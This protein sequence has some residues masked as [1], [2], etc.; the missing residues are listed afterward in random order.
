MQRYAQRAL[1]GVLRVT[2]GV[3]RPTAAASL[4]GGRMF[5]TDTSTMNVGIPKER[6]GTEQRVALTP[7]GVK[8]LKKLGYNV[9]IE[10]GAGERASFPDAAYEAEGASIVDGDAAMEADIVFKVQSPTVEEV[11]KLRPQGNIISFLYPAQNAD[12]VSALQ[13]KKATSLAMDCVPRI[14]RAQVFD[15]LSS[16]ANIAG[17]KAVIEAAN[18]FGRFF[19]GQMTAAGALPPA[20]VL[21]IGGGVAGLSSVATARSL[22]AIV[23]AFDT[24]AAVKEQVESLG[25]DFLTVEME[26]SGEGGGGYAKEM[27]QEFLDAEMALFKKQAKEI[28][29]IITTALIPGKRAPLLIKKEALDVMKPGSVIVDLAAEAGGN[30]EGCMHGEIVTTHNGVKILGFS[31]L[32]SR[33]SG[34]SSMLY[35]NNISK[36]LES[37]TKE[38]K[39]EVNLQDEVIRGA[40]VTTSDGDMIW[41]DPNPPLVEAPKSKKV[42]TKVVKQEEDPYKKTLK[43][44]IG[45]GTGLFSLIGMGV[46][47]PDLAFMKMFTTFSLAIVAGYQSVFGVTPALHTPLMSI[48]NAI[49]GMTA[50]GGLLL[51][52][53]GFLPGNIPQVLAST[54][55]LASA[56]NI[57]GG[58][59]VTKRMLDMFK[60]PGD[61]AEHTNLWAIPGGMAISALLI[62]HM[63][64][65]PNIYEMGYLAASLCCIGGI[66]GL[67]KQSTARI[68]NS[69]GMIG[70]STGVITSLAQ[71]SFPFPLFMQAVGLMGI[72]G[73][74]GTYIGHKVPITSL[75]ETVAI[76]HSLVGVAAVTTSLASFFITGDPTLLHTFS[77]FLGTAIGSITTTGSI[78]AFLK[79][80]GIVKSGFHLPGQQYLNKPLSAI[81][82]VAGAAMM[83]NPISLTGLA[84]ILT[85]VATTFVLGW[86]I[87]NCVGAADMPV[88]ITVLNSYS[89]WAL[90][91]EGFMLNNIMLTIVGSLIGSSGAILSYIMCVAMNRSLPNVVFGKYGTL[92]QGKGEAMKIEGTHTEV[93]A[94]HVGELL[95]M[96]KK[97]VIVPGY[98]LAAAQGQYPLAEFVKVL[99]NK[100]IDV[101]FAIHPVAGR[102]PGQLNVILAE[103][104]IPYDIVYEMDDI[105]KEFDSTDVV[106]VEGANDIV[107]SSAIEDPN[108]S[109]AGMPVLEV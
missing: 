109:I 33:L 72:S 55:V 103:V 62:S 93:S 71:L 17:Y 88:M 106:L 4:L 101:K 24:R 98:G 70:I 50:V 29:I 6:L 58:F 28:D 63:V 41:P 9:S 51:L 81:T 77:C 22:G 42:E 79:L 96:A 102:M 64:G 100:K 35:S 31:D 86:N 1:P 69:L 76:F 16:M 21:V 10:S 15:A 75:P 14:S 44:T 97:V 32:P 99:R 5:G 108:S 37:M 59:M 66:S 94:D 107:N 104:G 36:L 65:V 92:T 3:V 49:S 52:G 30:V 45:T 89:G 61:P 25:A 105:N 23:R 2:K 56:V 27:S 8:R 57:G 91:A 90:C 84:A 73:T 40:I 7:E 83:Y 68:G 54:A 85:T 13:E 34:A 12:I 38:G 43:K 11:G 46:L 67:A 80:S 26:E 74:L 95:T 78:A 82:L 87:T 20:K 60:R 19:T 53:G 18:L 47:C 39:Y 48:T